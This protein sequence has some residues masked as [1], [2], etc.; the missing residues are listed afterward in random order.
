MP[1]VRIGGEAKLLYNGV[2][3]IGDG[4]LA[5]ALVRRRVDR[6]D[7]VCHAQGSGRFRTF[8]QLA[9]RGIE[10]GI[11]GRMVLG[12]VCAFRLRMSIR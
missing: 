9:L 12:H 5:R 7:A 11:I 2:V 4:R 6:D 3:S 10:D 8:R 1:G